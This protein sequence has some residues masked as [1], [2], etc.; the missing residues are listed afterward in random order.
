MTSV[1]SI[2]GWVDQ[3][4]EMVMVSGYND[5][6]QLY[7]KGLVLTILYGKYPWRNVL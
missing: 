1:L 5:L 3:T 2:F 4:P 7:F 6:N